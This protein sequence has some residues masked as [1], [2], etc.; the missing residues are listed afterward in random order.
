VLRICTWPSALCCVVLAGACDTEPVVQLGRLPERLP[1]ASTADSADADS[2]DEC[3]EY[4]PI[5]GSD[6]LTYRNLCKTLAARV[7]VAKRGPC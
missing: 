5:C 3:T 6:G 2:D 1:D 4:D 7:T